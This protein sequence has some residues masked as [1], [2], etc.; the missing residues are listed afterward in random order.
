MIMEKGKV[1]KNKM[2]GEGEENVGEENTVVS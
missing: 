2:M 1:M